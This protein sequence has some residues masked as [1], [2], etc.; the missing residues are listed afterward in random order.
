MAVLWSNNGS[1]IP[2]GVRKN[3]R[4]MLCQFQTFHLPY[5][6]KNSDFQKDIGTKQDKNHC[7]HFYRCLPLPFPRIKTHIQIQECF[8]FPW[9]RG[10]NK[11]FICPELTKALSGTDGDFFRLKN[12]IKSLVKIVWEMSLDI[13]GVNSHIATGL[14]IKI[15]V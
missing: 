14:G 12:I 8:L 2:I 13:L 3:S 15:N 9:Y 5:H 1:V 10:L 11:K 7:F 6:T 4:E